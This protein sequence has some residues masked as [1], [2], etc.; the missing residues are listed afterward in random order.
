MSHPPPTDAGSPNRRESRPRLRLTSSRSS[1]G[2][3]STFSEASLLPTVVEG[4]IQDEQPDEHRQPIVLSAE[5]GLRAAS[6]GD[7]KTA[8]S[9]PPRSIL[10][11]LPSV[12]LSPSVS[13][14]SRGTDSVFAGSSETAGSTHPLS[15]S[16]S[17]KTRVRFSEPHSLPSRSSSPAFGY[18]QLASAVDS[19]GDGAFVLEP[20]VAPP[21][22]SLEMDSAESD[23]RG[24]SVVASGADLGTSTSPSV[25]QEGNERDRRD[26]PGRRSGPPAYVPAAATPEADVDGGMES[27]PNNAH[28]WH[29]YRQRATQLDKDLLE[30]W[31]N[32][33]MILLVFAGLFSAVATGF[34]LEASKQLQPDFAE[35]TLH[36][37][38]NLLS[39]L[40]D[41][42]RAPALPDINTFNAPERAR[43]INGLWFIS[44]TLSLVVSLLAILVKQWIVEYTAKMRA[45]VEHARR[46]AWRHFAYRR[47]LAKWGVG[48]IISSLTALLHAALFLFL[49]GL[50]GFLFNLDPA[51]FASTAVLSALAATLYVAA[52][53]AP[54]WYGDCPSTTPLL[55]HLRWIFLR[56]LWLISGLMRLRKRSWEI[57]VSTNRGAFHEDSVLHGD[58]PRRDA[59]VLSWMVSSLP[60]RADVKI[61]LDAFSCLNQFTS[62]DLRVDRLKLTYM[63]ITSLSA[64]SI[65][66]GRDLSRETG[67]SFILD[68]LVSVIDR[69]VDTRPQLQE[70][71]IQ[72]TSTGNWYLRAL[73]TWSF[74]LEFAEQL[75]VPRH[76]IPVIFRAYT[77]ILERGQLPAAVHLQTGLVEQCL[78]YFT[79]SAAP[80]RS[81]SWTI[82]SLRAAGRLLIRALS[83]RTPRSERLTK[84]A[85][86]ILQHATSG[87]ELQPDLARL[88]VRIVAAMQRVDSHSDFAEQ[89]RRT[90]TINISIDLMEANILRP[91]AIISRNGDRRSAS[92]WGLV[93]EKASNDAPALC[94]TAMK[95]AVKL[96]LLCGISGQLGEV[97]VEDCQD[98]L[99]DLVGGERAV[100][101]ATSD[102]QRFFHL[103]QHVQ[104]VWPEWWIDARQRLLD[105]AAK[106]PREVEQSP[107]D[108][109][110]HTLV[111]SID[112]AGPCWKCALA[113]LN[114]SN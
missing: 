110:L 63:S 70:R 75:A 99:R 84:I 67:A 44:L 87:V 60:L 10:R 20:Y 34:L 47:G 32:T 106:R 17:E 2:R 105:F 83:Q 29:V 5:H 95:L 7:E 19:P 11:P 82:P 113:T 54:L 71:W 37:A 107:S 72:M 97:D 77:S 86:A 41:T 18:G 56:V 73:A 38:L 3:S 78:G 100:S 92:A 26:R 25:S 98:L 88:A 68:G 66:V 42:V 16:P 21:L 94:D 74:V 13:S 64:L 65:I 103:A 96:S 102:S 111:T 6:S 90:G 108:L 40:D 33:L 1:G 79:S 12:P 8:P 93:L 76:E 80:A 69:L 53:C 49:T 46:W 62:T 39:R 52:T 50:I 45:P 114:R 85:A 27:D 55:E 30:G 104:R 15:A 14:T 81:H 61:A 35:Q 9:R 91:R 57:T 59:E 89:F 4:S 51:V 101:L 36:V 58:E 23:D 43:W 31:D 109:Q 24:P 112:S 48:G 22:Y 28:V